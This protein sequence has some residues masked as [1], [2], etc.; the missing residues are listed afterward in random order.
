M[1]CSMRHHGQFSAELSAVTVIH[2]TEDKINVPVMCLQCDEASCVKVCSTKALA[3]GEDG[4]VVHD[5][6]RCV[7]CKFCVQACPLGMISYAPSI[8]GIIKCDTCEGAA[9]CATWCPTNAIS[10]GEPADDM[11]RKLSVAAG[12]KDGRGAENT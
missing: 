12:I 3:R 5:A 7:V 11:D 10:F 6:N 1:L 8:S 4:V 9:L 2:F